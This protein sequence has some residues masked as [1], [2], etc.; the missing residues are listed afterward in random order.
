MGAIASPAEIERQLGQLI[1]RKSTGG[2]HV[3]ALTSMIK[4]A[5]IFYTVV[6]SKYHEK[7]A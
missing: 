2:Y 5:R 1:E 3:C 7:I 6:F 4:D